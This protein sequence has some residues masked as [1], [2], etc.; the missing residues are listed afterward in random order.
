MPW[1]M[2]ANPCA[3]ALPA[4]TVLLFSARLPFV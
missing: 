4:M 2:L 3:Y 1:E